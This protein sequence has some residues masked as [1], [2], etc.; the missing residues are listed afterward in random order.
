MHV[1]NQAKH[2]ITVEKIELLKPKG[3]L[4][5]PHKDQLRKIWE[6]VRGIPP[7][8]S[9]PQN[10]SGIIQ[11]PES[12][13]APSLISIRVTIADNRPRR[14]LKRHTIKRKITD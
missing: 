3:G 12:T 7:N 2:A 14:S 13:S 11:L 9:E 8:Q 1:T 4:I 10:I 6:K 5:G